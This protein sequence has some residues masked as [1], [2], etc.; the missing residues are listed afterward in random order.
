MTDVN[1]DSQ[2]AGLRGSGE[3]ALADII[4]DH[5]DRLRRIVDLRLDPRLCRRID[6]EDV[7]QESFLEARKRLSRFLDHPSVSVFVW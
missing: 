5:H 6:P 1:E 7:L 2:I 4:A 3:K